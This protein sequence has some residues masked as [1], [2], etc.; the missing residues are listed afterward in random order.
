MFKKQRQPKQTEQSIYTK[1]LITRNVCL[2]IDLIGNNIESHL[3]NIISSDIEGKCTNEGY[4][5]RG[6]SRILTTSSGTLKDVYVIF[7]VV[8]ECLICCPV[9]GMY[10]NCIVRDINNSGIEAI[11]LNESP[12]PFIV[13]IAR[14]HYNKNE[15]FLSI[16][17]NDKI[18][19]Q[20]IRQRYELYD[21]MI[22]II[23][24]LYN[25]NK[26]PKL[27]IVPDEPTIPEIIKPQE[28]PPGYDE[29]FEEHKENPVINSISSNK[30]PDEPD[31]HDEHDEHDEPDEPDEPEKQPSDIESLSTDE[32]IN[33]ISKVVEGMYNPDI[34]FVFYALSKNV[35]P[36]KGNKE[37]LPKEFASEYI[38]LS[39][40]DNWRQKLS[41]YAFIPFE[42]NGLHW[43]TVE[44]YVEASKFKL[45]NPEFYKLFSVESNSELS[46]NL[47]YLK[48][49]SSKSG[50][51]KDVLVRPKGVKIDPDFYDSHRNIK[52]LYYAQLHKFMDNQELRNLLL[53]TK[54]ARLIHN[55]PRNIESLPYDNLIYFRYLI[56]ENLI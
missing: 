49:V 20:V 1:S 35:Y 42:L 21:P 6:S 32:I 46:K 23:G 11:S 27:N 13:F 53:A 33:N 16:K 38:E 8:I 37:K 2:T 15:Y 7:E 30:K 3:L 47:D 44:H 56:K 24:E 52:E 14:D 48:A 5:K 9:Q 28:L 25:E 26:K 12:S 31:E 51:L 10:I 40:I 19:I 29:G 36:G 54:N 18:I 41:N 4:I 39:K 55:V 34:E 50:K 43:N 22:S 45:N 17:E